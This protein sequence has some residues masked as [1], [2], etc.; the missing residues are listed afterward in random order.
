M[1]KSGCLQLSG[2]LHSS[3]R[4]FLPLLG[5]HRAALKPG[6]IPSLLLERPGA[7]LGALTS[8][9]PPLGEQTHDCEVLDLRMS[10]DLVGRWSSVDVSVRVRF[11]RS[12]AASVF[13]TIAV[14][15]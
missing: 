14:I 2:G 12:D 7:T 15:M 8:P 13:G 3:D 5:G 9:S 4:A 11:Q 6:T 10:L 1:A